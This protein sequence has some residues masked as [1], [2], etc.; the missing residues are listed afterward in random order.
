MKHVFSKKIIKAGL[1]VGALDILAAC[2][3][4]Y[5]KTGK[6]P[7]RVLKFIASG[8]FGK[9]ANTNGNIMILWGLIFH[10]FIA[11]SFTLFFFWLTDKIPS[12]LKNKLLT[13]AVYGIFIW[14]VMKF[15]VLPLSNTHKIPFNFINA[16]I[17]I[18]ILIVCIGIPLAFLKG[19]STRS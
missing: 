4:Y 8:V 12:V 18:L 1:I 17:A 10:F 3:Q 15:L 5:I 11:F 16:I 2:I 9:A 6:N 14:S 7:E 19:K 13:G